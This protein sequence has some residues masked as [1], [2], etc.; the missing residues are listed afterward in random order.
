MIFRAI[1]SVV[2]SPEVDRVAHQSKGNWMENHIFYAKK[3]SSGILR[4][5]TRKNNWKSP[6]YIF[7]DMGPSEFLIFLTFLILAHWLK[8]KTSPRSLKLTASFGS[9]KALSQPGFVLV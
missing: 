6:F 8:N 7:E 4:S 2:F 5:K 1:L 9:Y 3:S